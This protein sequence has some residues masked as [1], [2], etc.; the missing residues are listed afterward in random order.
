MK[1]KTILIISTEKWGD[2]FVSK[3]HYANYLS[4]NNTV[5][6]LGPP[7][8]S[9]KTPIQKQK[10]TSTQLSDNLT[11]VEYKNILPR[12]NT[13]PKRIQESTFK[14]TAKNIEQFIG[15]KIDII[16]SFDPYRFFNQE[17]WSADCKIYHSADIHYNAK[18]EDEIVRS[19][20]HL[21]TISK[22]L[23]EKLPAGTQTNVTGHGTDI[24][25]NSKYN[26]KLPGENKIK[27]IAIGNFSNYLD[28][29]L[30]GKIADF[31]LNIDFIFVG[32]KSKSNLGKTDEAVVAQIEELEKRSNMFFIGPVH[33]SQLND[34]LSKADINLT[35]YKSELRVVN[36]HK[37]L[38]YLLSGNVTICSFISDYSDADKDLILILEDNNDLPK[39]IKEVAS[40]LDFWNHS[41]KKAMRSEYAYERNYRQKIQQ[42]TELIEL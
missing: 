19:S 5:Y 2:N 37:I 41:E 31:N 3:H 20:H 1:N 8:G 17:V 22:H 39:T 26:A 33:Y 24:A 10:I 7:E 11:I 23:E 16:W 27:A 14:K 25:S 9:N 12:L 29:D 38:S 42:I 35:L 6:F 18:Y 4:E 30:L 32:P 34:L 28:Y 36:T 13:L 15:E 40:N 21:F